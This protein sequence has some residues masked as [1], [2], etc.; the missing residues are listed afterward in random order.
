MKRILLYGATGR[1][2]RHI[3][4]YALQKGYE[5]TALVRSPGKL[6]IKSDKLKV[7]RGLPTNIEDVRKAIHGCNAVISTLSGLPESQIITFKKLNPP[8]IME[9][10]ILNTIQC[11]N[12]IGIKRIVT[13]SSI[14]VGDSYPYA[15]WFMRMGIKLTNFKISFADHNAQEELLRRSGLDWVI[16]R[17][18][19]LNDNDEQGDLVISYNNKPAVFKMS[20]K[21]LAKFLVDAL[22]SNEFVQKSPILS[23]KIH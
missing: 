10:A 9:T 18:V 23:E 8:H 6:N 5:I 22:E 1:T 20:R 2:G 19:A 15:P 7:I 17:P 16:A 12:E 14:G 11:M 21:R 4:D 13:L 3:I